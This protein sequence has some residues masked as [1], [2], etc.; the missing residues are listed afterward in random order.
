[1]YMP[2]IKQID[3]IAEALREA[4]REEMQRDPAVILLGEDIGEFGGAFQVTRGL[5]KEFG[6]ERVR[7]TPISEIAIIGTAIGAALTG[8]R[9]VAEIQYADFLTC[10]M[11]QIANQAAKIRLMTGG[12][13]KVPIVIRAPV[14]S[15]TRGAQHGQSVE[16]WFMHTPGL[17]VAV[18]S[19]PYEAKGLLKM[20]IRDDNPVMFFEHK[21]LYGSRSPGGKLKGTEGAVTTVKPAPYEEYTI[22]FGKADVKKEGKD[23]TVVAT[24]LMVHKALRVA[25]RLE[26]E[27]GISVE[28]IDPCT[29]VPLD[30]ETILNSVKKTGRLVVISED[31]TRG[32]VGS[33]IAAIVAEKA[34]DFLDAPIKRVGALNTPIP[35]A[36]NVEKHVIPNEERIFLA[37]KEVL[38]S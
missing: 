18:P 31:C 20:A 8:M 4:L 23:V 29:L 27:E 16:A 32:G 34:L 1:M 36:P 38:S 22:P 30:E 13:A 35:F 37:I 7:N 33:E 5:I 19:T 17:K 26:K 15:A 10:C 9:P 14:G 28:V 2:E 6:K 21:L 11:D 24:L 25:E 12:Q 3:T